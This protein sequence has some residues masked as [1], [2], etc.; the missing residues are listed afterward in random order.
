MV[1]TNVCI[2]IVRALVSG[3]LLN[4]TLGMR[5]CIHMYDIVKAMFSSSSKL[6]LI[7]STPK[8]IP[9]ALEKATYARTT[10]RLVPYIRNSCHTAYIALVLYNQ[11]NSIGGSDS[12]CL[13]RFHLQ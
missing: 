8:L 2:F 11:T 7:N 1:T 6:A 10:V 13:K 3:S 12:I 5:Y 4:P 9:I